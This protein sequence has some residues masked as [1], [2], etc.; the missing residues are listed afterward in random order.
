MLNHTE[1]PITSVCRADL[2]S[3]GFDARATDDATMRKLASKLADDYCEQLFW[4]SLEILA[5]RLRIP[6][7]DSER[8]HER[9]YTASGVPLP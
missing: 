4:S 3:L 5:D 8:I 2:E 6:R 1:Y 9:P 7:R